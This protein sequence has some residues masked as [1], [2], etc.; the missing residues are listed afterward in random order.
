LFIV[1]RKNK[2][3]IRTVAELSGLIVAALGMIYTSRIVGPEYI[4]YSATA[5]AVIILLGRLADCGLSSY[6][7]QKL[8]RDDEK[9]ETLLTIIVPP[10]FVLASIIILIAFVFTLFL[11]IGVT[12][13]Y[14]LEVS[15]WMVFFEAC[16]PYWVFVA[17]GKINIASIIRIVQSV[18]YGGA[19]VL[20]IRQPEDWKYLPFLTLFNSSINFFLA[21]Y[22]LYSSRLKVVDRTLIVTGYLQ[23]LKA[24]YKEGFHFLKAELS[25]YVYTTSDRLFLYY[26][27]GPHV[28]GIYEAAYKI[29]NPFYSIN[30]VITPTMFRDLAQSFKHGY[31]YQVLAKYVFSMSLLTIPLGFYLVYF[32]DFV[33]KVL[34]GTRF[35]ES[36]TSLSILGFVI[37]FG[38]TSGTLAQPFCAWNMQREFGTAVFWG[39]ILNIIMNFA[40]IPFYGAAG[41]AVATL[42]AKIIVTVVAYYY[43]KNVTNY[44]VVT[45]FTWFFIASLVPLVFVLIAAQFTTNNYLLTTVYGVLYFA[46][47][48]V[49]YRKVFRARMSQIEASA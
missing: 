39:N 35:A 30:N 20:F 44:P 4:G 26:F 15:I 46:I 48:F 42:A 2:F 32:S 1:N 38:F 17:M 41:A 10:K 33:V 47:I 14:F 40:L 11:P 28:V 37:T 23:M 21:V 27:A 16:S 18:L 49:I 12:L 6:A 43:F 5:S 25:G 34:Y 29:I 22:F 9:I 36:A 45:D 7:S 31:V 3:T 19:I 8:A 13:R 24:Y